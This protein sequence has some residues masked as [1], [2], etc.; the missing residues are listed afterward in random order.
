MNLIDELNDEGTLT[1]TKTKE[2]KQEETPR[3]TVGLGVIPDY[4]FDGRGMRI[5]GVREDKVADKAE[6]KKGDIVIQMG[7]V[8]VI[9]MMSYMKALSQF[10]KGD[11]T[12]VKV[13]REET[14][15]EKNITFF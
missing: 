1:F 7:D 15:I 12:T 13:K 5:D 9:D 4:L 3:F 6:L 10:V 14:V 11:S 2:T 8:E